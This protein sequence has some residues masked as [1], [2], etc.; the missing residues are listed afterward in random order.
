MTDM[1]IDQRSFMYN[2]NQTIHEH[3]DIQIKLYASL[4]LEEVSELGEALDKKEDSEILKEAVDVI[5]VTLGLM[6]SFGVDPSD[7]W[8]LVHKNNMSKVLNQDA[9]VKDINGKIMK[10]PESIKRKADMMKGIKELL[11]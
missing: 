10:S 2:G 3:N 7:V 11:K 4:I 8:E 5:V 1:A 9:I 6:W